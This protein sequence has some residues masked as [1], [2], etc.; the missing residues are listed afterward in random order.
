MK[1]LFV[2]NNAYTQG[3][4]L[5]TSCRR[6]VKGLREAGEEVR[7]LSAVGPNK[8]Q[9][10]YVLP[11]DTI[12]FFNKI[13]QKQGYAFAKRD[14]AIIRDA[15]R[16]AD[17]IHLEEPFDLQIRTAKLAEEENKPLTATYHLHPENFYASVHLAKSKY[18]NTATM[19]VWLDTVFNHCQII[20]CPTDDVKKRL[21]K[22]KCKAQ[23]RVISNGILHQTHDIVKSPINK[24]NEMFLIITT[25]R[26]SIE[27]DQMTLL[28]AIR[29]SKYADRI[30]LVLAGKGPLENKLHSEAEKLV[31]DGVLKYPP[32]FGFYSLSELQA[33]Y[34]QADLY[35]HC[36]TVEVEGMSCMEAIESGLVPII[37]KGK[38]TATHQFSNHADNLYRE[39][40]AKDLAKKIDFWLSDD[41]RR[42][43]EAKKYINKGEEYDI[44]KS[45]TALQKMF[46]DAIDMFSNNIQ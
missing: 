40:D 41:K 3:N 19:K 16:W 17:V 32:I 23:L 46:K 6:T 30:L 43:L 24:E 15:V 20:Q 38:L 29:F 28:K 34:R 39:H 31:N 27:K 25:G 18:F 26:Y 37:A 1:I 14:D 8:E 21:E 44:G 7:I 12:P 10:D 11:Y 13:I 42:A 22:W 9:P 2:I 45:I 5:A 36:A 35:I 4:G 33:I